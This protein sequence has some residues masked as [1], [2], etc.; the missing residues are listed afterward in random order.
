M[1]ALD[2]NELRETS[3]ENK[4]QLSKERRDKYQEGAKALFEV[5]TEGSED[6]IREASEAGSFR[7]ILYTFT[8]ESDEVGGMAPQETFNA[9]GVTREESIFGLLYNHFNGE[10]E[11]SEEQRSGRFKIYIQRLKNDAD[12]CEFAL[13]ID[14]DAKPHFSQKMVNRRI[15]NYVRNYNSGFNPGKPTQ[16]QQQAHRGRSSPQDEI[17]RNHRQNQGQNQG[18]APNQGSVPNQRFGQGRPRQNKPKS[19]FGQL[20]NKK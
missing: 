3:R 17:P 15:G 10:S 16:R 1:A 2:I 14:W 11:E 20:F 12:P 19:T 9:R 7:T 5:I 8:K 6:K 18:S 4:A 13:Y